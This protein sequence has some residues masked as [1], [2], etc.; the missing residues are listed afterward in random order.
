M[1]NAV[2]TKRLPG[3]VKSLH[4]TCT[5]FTHAFKLTN[6]VLFHTITITHK[7]TIR[8]FTGR[9]TDCIVL[10]LLP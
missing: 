8:R 7:R 9:C 1:Q 10:A 5:T 3:R 2:N 6:I 4:I